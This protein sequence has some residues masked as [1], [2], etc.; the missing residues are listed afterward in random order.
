MISL[1][2]FITSIEPR[3]GRNDIIGYSIRYACMCMFAL[4]MYQSELTFFYR[5]EKC[6]VCTAINVPRYSTHSLTI[7]QFN[8]KSFT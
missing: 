2:E 1:I 7:F 4:K 6:V 5:Y 3:C 8:L